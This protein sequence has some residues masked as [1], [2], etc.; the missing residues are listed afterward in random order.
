MYQKAPPELVNESDIWILPD[1]LDEGIAMLAG[2]RMMNHRG[3]V[4]D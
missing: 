1:E 3:E 4:E 2:A